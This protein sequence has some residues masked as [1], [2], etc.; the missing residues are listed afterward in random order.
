MAL[1]GVSTASFFFSVVV[2][3]S[4]GDLALTIVGSGSE[5]IERR[6]CMRRSGT[7]R[8]AGGSAANSV[9]CRRRARVAATSSGSNTAT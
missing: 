2:F 3:L 5:S 1:R 8:R 6:A 4:A 9:T 7:W